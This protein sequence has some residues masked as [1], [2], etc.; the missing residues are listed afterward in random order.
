MP[1][2]IFSPVII[3]M[4]L[5]IKRKFPVN[6]Q[7]FLFAVVILQKKSKLCTPHNFDKI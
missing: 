5:K 1:S 2:C 7:T 6:E 4:V 3:N